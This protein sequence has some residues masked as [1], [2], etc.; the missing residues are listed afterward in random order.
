MAKNGFFELAR[1]ADRAAVNLLYNGRAKAAEAVISDLQERGPL[2]SG[3]FANSWRIS[4]PTG[5]QSGGSGQQ[6]APVPVKAPSLTGADVR[7]K[8]LGSPFKIDNVAD[9]A[10]V[11]CDLKPGTFEDPGIAPLKEPSYGNRENSIRGE[12]WPVPST[13]GVDGGN[14]ATAPLDWF[15]TYVDGGEMDRTIDHAM[16]GAERGFK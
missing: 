2:W 3:Q 15:S 5:T 11:A 8:I 6:T 4:T 13:R 14:R 12:P 10:D 7:T 16:K 9:Y 1:W